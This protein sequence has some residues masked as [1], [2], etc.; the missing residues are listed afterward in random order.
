MRND[1]FRKGLVVGII[2]LFVGTSLGPSIMGESEKGN[3]TTINNEHNRVF[4]SESRILPGFHSSPDAIMINRTM[5]L[6]K[7]NNLLYPSEPLWYWA[8][9]GGGNSDAGSLSIFVDPSG[10]S[11]ITG[12]FIGAAQFGSTTL[13]SYGADDVFVAKL[14]TN[15]VWQWAVQAGGA[16]SEQANGIYGDSSGNIYITGLFRSSYAWFG[17]TTLTSRGWEDVFIAKL[18]SNGVWQWAVQAGGTSEDEGWGISVDSSGNSYIIG[19]FWEDAQFGST[20][21][22]SIASSADI[23]VAKL[24]T[25][26]AWQWA[27]QAGGTEWDAGIGISASP[28]G[29]PYITGCFMGVA[30]FGSTTLTSN[31]DCDV[32]VAKLNTNGVWQWAIRTGGGG[33]GDTDYGFGISVD[34]SGNSYVTGWIATG[35]FVAKVNSNGVWQ[36]EVRLGEHYDQGY[37]ICVDSIGNPYITGSVGDNVF[38]AKLNT[39]G[40]WQW[41]VSAGGTGDDI[42]RGIGIDTVGNIYITGGFEGTATFG[43]Y[44]LTSQG[45]SNVFVAKLIE[46]GSHDW[47]D[48]SQKKYSNE[49]DL[50]IH[51]SIWN[52]Q[53]FR[54]SL[55][56]LTRV[57]IYICRYNNPPNDLTIRIRNSLTGTDLTSITIDKNTIPKNVNSWVEA[58]FPDISINTKIPYYLILNTQ[59]GEYPE[60]NYG[61]AYASKDPYPPEKKYWSWDNGNNWN[62][63]GHEGDFCFITY[64]YNTGG[65]SNGNLCITGYCPIDLNVT[66]PQGRTINLTS[67]TIPNATYVEEDLD[68]IGDLD[69]QIFIPDALDGNYIIQVIP[70][71]DANQTDNYSIIVNYEGGQYTLAE[72]VTIAEI[73]PE[74]YIYTTIRPDQPITPIGPS[75]GKTGTEYT[76]QTAATHPNGEQLWYQWDWGE[77]NFSDWIGPYLSGETIAMNHSWNK[78]GLY[79]IWVR[80]KTTCDVRSFW[81]EPVE[82][83]ITINY[84][85]A[86]LLGFIKNKNDTGNYITFNAHLLCYIGSSPLTI[87]VLKSSE[88]LMI[89]MQNHRGFIGNRSIIGI[90]DTAIISDISSSKKENINI[91]DYIKQSL[92]PDSKLTQ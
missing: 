78:K 30:Q 81:S 71:P 46:G 67:S 60:N 7:G 84:L 11:Y 55:N 26:G 65:K 1:I 70:K 9:S 45:E 23:F 91:R 89:S 37:G 47:E 33:S 49:G 59:G 66:D 92:T 44:I 34:S 20:T 72:N 39:N 21:L 31:G 8:V 69:D 86:F 19:L 54:P 68:G 75:M 29:N 82:I 5:D 74:P 4:P 76:F 35:L 53:G 85:K 6:N 42:S 58:D 79:N 27:I 88:L 15:G 73:P 62:A 56:V 16:G 25:N 64:G 61:W 87:K 24:N 83:N 57:K 38:V 51:E 80:A 50:A 90:F 41:T 48:Q 43:P 17:S 28:S 40:A 77:G 63:E 22:T 52:A 3:N 32:F 10:N 14:N 36:W 2:L 12:G 13:Y 18:N